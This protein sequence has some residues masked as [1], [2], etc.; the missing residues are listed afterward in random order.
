MKELKPFEIAAVKRQFQNSLPTLKKIEAINEKIAKL[1]EEKDTL[2]DFLKGGEQ[3]IMRLTGGYMSTDL[4]KCTYELVWNEDGSPKT[5]KD[6]RQL[7]KRI[8]T[9]NPP[10]ETETVQVEMPEHGNDYDVDK[11]TVIEAETEEVAPLENEENP[12]NI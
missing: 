5:D 4:I 10:V 12:F 6:G 7:K 9:Y 11:A 3:G 8:L 2:V 1:Q